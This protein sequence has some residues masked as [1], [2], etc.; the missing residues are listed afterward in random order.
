MTI[1]TNQYIATA[2]DVEKLAT[3]I[4]TAD[5]TA[6]GGRGTYLKALVGTTQAELGSPPRMRNVKA[7][8]VEGDDA[9]AHLKAFEL[10]FKRFHDAVVKAAEAVEPK[11]DSETLR[12]RTAFSRSAGSTLRGYIRAG[13]DVRAIAAHKVTKAAL[14]TP[15]TKR[16]FS[17]DALKKRAVDA[18]GTLAGIVKNLQAANSA[19][20]KEAVTAILAQLAQAAGMTQHTSKDVEHAV[21]AG[22]AFHTK[23]GIFLPISLDAVREQRRAAA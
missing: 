22:E 16:K 20:A 3:E 5:Q 10:V 15:R 2:L 9:V 1:E 23:T 14:A 12:A 11:P 13:N 21:E 18:A 7:E 8:K 4:L 6:Q 17:V 19:E